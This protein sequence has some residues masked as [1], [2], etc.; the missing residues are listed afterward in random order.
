MFQFSI[1]GWRAYKIQN[2]ERI[3]YGIVALLEPVCASVYLRQETADICMD[4]KALTREPRAIVMGDC[5]MRVCDKVI[6]HFELFRCEANI[7]ATNCHVMAQ[8][9]SNRFKLN[10]RCALAGRERNAPQVR[11]NAGE[12]SGMLNGLVT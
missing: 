4:R 12:S 5:N 7:L 9:H 10:D 6:E 1:L 8:I 3:P 11:S 2:Q